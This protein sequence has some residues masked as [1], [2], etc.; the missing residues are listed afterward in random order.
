[1]RRLILILMSLLLVGRAHAVEETSW[2]QLKQTVPV[3]DMPWA[4]KPVK[5]INNNLSHTE[6]IGPDGGV[7]KCET[8]GGPKKGA[9]ATFHVPAGALKEPVEIT[10]ELVIEAD[11]VITVQFAPGGLVFDVLSSLEV[12]VSETA[13]PQGITSFTAQHIYADGTVVEVAT[14]SDKKSQTQIRVVVDVP[15]FSRYGL[16]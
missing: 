16:R 11:G 15:G 12:R 14:E 10:M 1:M 6:W 5:V 4:A 8:R 7:I 2:G 13:Y 9:S 3:Q